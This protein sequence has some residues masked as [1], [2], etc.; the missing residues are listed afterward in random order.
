MDQDFRKNIKVSVDTP[1]SEIYIA[2]DVEAKKSLRST[3]SQRPTGPVAFHF[4]NGEEKLRGTF[5]SV[6]FEKIIS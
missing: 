1:E 6:F 3:K 4:G 5:V 2:A